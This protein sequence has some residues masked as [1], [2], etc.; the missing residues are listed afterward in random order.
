MAHRTEMTKLSDI[1]IRLRAG[2]SHNDINRSL[3]VHKTVIRR[4]RTLAEE[5]A[6]LSADTPIPDD[7]ELKAKYDALFPS[8]SIPHPLDAFRDE[9]HSWREAGESFTVI[10]Y[11][12]RERMECNSLKDTRLRDY[13]HKHFPRLPKPVMRREPELAVA[14]MDFGFLGTCK[15]DA[16]VLHKTWFI[17]VR[18]RYSRYAYREYLLHT[19]I[20]S[21]VDALIRAFEYFGAVPQRLVIDN[22]KAAVSKAHRYDPTLTQ[23]FRDFAKHYGVLIEPCRPYSPGHKGGVETD[24]KYV[25]GNFLPLLYDY[26]KQRGHD[27]I[28]L[29]VINERFRWW[30]DTVAAV[31]RIREMADRTPM[32]LIQE[33]YDHLLPLPGERHSIIE[34][35]Q[36][37]TVHDDW[38]VRFN[39]VRYSVPYRHRGRTDARIRASFS[40][41][42]VFIDNEL[43]ARHMRSRT[44]GAKVTVKEHG[45]QASMEYLALSKERLL[46]FAAEIGS[47]TRRFVSGFLKEG[48]QFNLRSARAVVFLTRRYPAARIEQACAHAIEHDLHTYYNIKN[49]LEKKLENTTGIPVDA[50]GQCHFM[51]ERTGD[52]YKNVLKEMFPWTHSHN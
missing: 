1:L 51:F 8:N 22:F 4:V 18:F 20:H 50:N 9:I 52:E 32:E 29:S 39:T 11:K 17:S 3:G 21:V 38:H 31:R 45:P 30:D 2:H 42:D 14:E 44:R 10:L 34:Y 7:F 16:G 28:R 19:D 35:A 5:N 27:I 23:S 43:V 47:S 33:E 24:V 46:S 12:L 48:Q 13:V 40:V 41:I 37:I 36:P 49:I 25:K 6:W 26:E 15:D